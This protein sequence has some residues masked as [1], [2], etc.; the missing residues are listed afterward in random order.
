MVAKAFALDCNLNLRPIRESNVSG[1]DNFCYI[2]TKLAVGGVRFTEV[3]VDQRDRRTSKC[4]IFC[5]PA[6]QSV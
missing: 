6:S 2:S 3:A 5:A 1:S 4:Y